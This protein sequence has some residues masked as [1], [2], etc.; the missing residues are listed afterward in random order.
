MMYTKYFHKLEQLYTEFYF[1]RITEKTQQVSFEL[2]KTDWEKIEEL[3]CK[4]WW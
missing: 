1:N 4:T 3:D 2:R